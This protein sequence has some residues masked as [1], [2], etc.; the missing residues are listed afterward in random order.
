MTLLIHFVL[1]SLVS[2]ATEE[3]PIPT[4]QMAVIDSAQFLTALDTDNAQ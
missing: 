3:K 1:N 4:N 2:A